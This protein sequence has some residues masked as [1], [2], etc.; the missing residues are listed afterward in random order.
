MQ[1]YATSLTTLVRYLCRNSL[2]RLSVE[3]HIQVFHPVLDGLISNKEELHLLSSWHVH[4]DCA[5]C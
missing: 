3:E 1:L 5:H 4:L 2:P